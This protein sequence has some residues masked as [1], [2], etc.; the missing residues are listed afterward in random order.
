[1]SRS[2]L[3]LGTKA[4][5]ECSSEI[6][7][8]IKRDIVRK[9][10]CSYSCRQIYFHKHDP[11]YK[12]NWKTTIALSNNPESNKKKSRPGKLNGRYLKDRNK[13]KSPRSR[14]ECTEWRKQVFER[15]NYTCQECGSRGG[16]LNADHIKPWCIFP[17]L[18]FDI[19]N[20]RTLCIKCHK[21]TDTYGW[22]MINILRKSNNGTL[23]QR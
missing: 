4:C 10:F 14:Y 6:K 18:R 8:T 9:K 7:L 23:Y 13:I 11:R 12:Q 20:G 15:D 16:R 22:K 1:M 5:L 19:N 21:K 17:E 2:R 3:N